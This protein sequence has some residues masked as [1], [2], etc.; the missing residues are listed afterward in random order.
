MALG[1]TTDLQLPVA[2]IRVANLRLVRRSDSVSNLAFEE[3]ANTAVMACVSAC[4]SGNSQLLLKASA[5][6][7]ERGGKFYAV[8][9][10]SPQTR[11][12]KIQV[13]TLIDDA[14]LAS[15]LGAKIVWL[16][17]SD[18]VGELLKFARQTRISRI[19]VLRSR[20]SI[21]SRL[22][23]RTFYSDLLS[24]AEGCRINVVGLGH[25]YLTS[26]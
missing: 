14:I 4:S 3:S 25:A 10:D 6:A 22:F 20:P 23:G 16:E 13:R 5:A 17:S 1:I 8:L 19:F 15:Y 24:R 18:T 7:R 12:G 2:P 9:V 21:F 11:S 26:G